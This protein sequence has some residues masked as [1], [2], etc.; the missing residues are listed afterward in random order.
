[1]TR[2][3][4]AQELARKIQAETDKPYTACLAEAKRRLAAQTQEAP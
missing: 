2:R 3:T 1:M 4:P